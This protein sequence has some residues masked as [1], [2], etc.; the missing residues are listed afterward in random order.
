LS[1]I[2]KSIDERI[3]SVGNPDVRPLVDEAW[4]CYGVGAFRATIVLTWLAVCADLSDK[5]DRLSD[6]GDGEAAEFL[7]K[8]LTAESHGLKSAGVMA[9]Q[10]VEREILSV[11][12][13][14]ELIDSVAERELS[15]IREDRHLCAHLSL[16]SAGEMYEPSAEIARAHLS[17]ALDN[18]LTLPATQG[19]RVVDRYLKH[20]LDPFFVVAPDHLIQ[21]FYERVRPAAR[22][23]IIDVTTKHALL[24]LEVAEMPGTE[25]VADRMAQCLKTF[26]ARDRN[27]VGVAISKNVDQLAHLGIGELV[28]TLQRVGGLDVFWEHVDDALLSRLE[29]RTSTLSP[30]GNDGRISDECASILSLSAIDSVARRLPELFDRFADLATPGKRQ[31]MAHRAGRCFAPSVAELLRDAR[32]FRNAEELAATI[33]VPHAVLLTLDDL[34]ALLAS[35]SGNTQCQF[36]SGMPG[37]AEEVFRRCGHLRPSSDQIWWKFVEEMRISSDGDTDYDE[38]YRYTNVE[39]LLSND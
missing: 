23:R 18:V 38:Y 22:R 24:A 35:W 25:V 12:T 28:T 39:R 32:S 10:E 33:V 9:M 3:A 6:D 30:I 14:V 11:A 20:V 7:K 37:M 15:R 29:T 1:D 17:C 34:A 21:T 19:K 26:A 8:L 27:A 2:V 13:Q 5:I 36:A 4:K 31:V 16:R